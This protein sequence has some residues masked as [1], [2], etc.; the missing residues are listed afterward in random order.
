MGYHADEA[1]DNLIFGGG[2][3]ARVRMSPKCERCK[4]QCVWS[5]N[6]GRWRLYENGKPHYCKPNDDDFEVIE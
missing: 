4:A 1:I 5:R 6:T 2:Y 3:F